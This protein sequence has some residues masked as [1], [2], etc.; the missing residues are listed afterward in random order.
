MASGR[1]RLDEIVRRIADLEAASNVGDGYAEFVEPLAHCAKCR[2]VGHADLEPAQA[3]RAFRCRSRVMPGPD[4][5]GDGMRH[6]A[7]PHIAHAKTAHDEESAE[8]EPV[9]V[10]AHRL[11]EVV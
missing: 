4:V 10:E 3:R 2:L 7:E 11:L 8:A 1:H 9:A 6:V 5:E